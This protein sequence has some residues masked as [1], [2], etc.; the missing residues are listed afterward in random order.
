MLTETQNEKTL[1]LHSMSSIDIVTIMNEQD[2]QI[3]EII[4][5]VLPQIAQAVD[6]I[7][8][9]LKHGGRIFYVGAGTSGRLGVMDAAECVPTFGTEPEMV[10]GIIAGGEN[11]TVLAKEDA[12]DYFEDGQDALK[13]KD[14]KSKDVVV[15]ISASGK[16]PFVIGAVSHAN[17]IGS[18][19]IGVA[20]NVPSS[21]L[22][23]VALAIALP[24]GPEI[25]TGS[26][27]LKAGT[28]QKMVLNMLSTASMVQLGKV[29][30][31]LMID[32]KPK[33]QKL[34]QRAQNIVKKLGQVDTER[35]KNI[36]EE[37]GNDVKIAI[38]MAK[39]GIDTES[40]RE[41]I[42]LHGGYLNQALASE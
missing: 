37:S 8:R 42:I 1:N 17:E 15:G 11:A 33:N 18:S 41:L 13:R 14:L 29:F 31:N 6:L 12:E 10:Q 25:L 9:N 38:L 20:C 28:A 24:V 30:Q 5:R 39:L 26:T 34:I 22:D 32:V 27:R 2:S 40:A 16:T 35:A 23:H 21:L 19:T 4:Q 36:L 3:T 7:A